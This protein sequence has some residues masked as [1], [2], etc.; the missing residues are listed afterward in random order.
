MLDV[1]E[2][3]KPNWVRQVPLTKVKK[4]LTEFPPSLEKLTYEM[5]EKEAPAV[6]KEARYGVRSPSGSTWDEV[7]E[8]ILKERR[9]KASTSLIRKLKSVAKQK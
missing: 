9:P 8:S 2:L 4:L 7:S 6:V 3:G 5:I 1:C